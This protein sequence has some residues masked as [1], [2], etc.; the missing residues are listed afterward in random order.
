MTYSIKICALVDNWSIRAAGTIIGETRATLELVDR[1][2][3]PWIYFTRKDIAV[4][5]LDYDKK[6]I[7]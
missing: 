2:R 7:Y 4:A 5:F 1:D 3:A 6:L